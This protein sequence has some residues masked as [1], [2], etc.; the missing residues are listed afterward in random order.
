M[1]FRLHSSTTFW[2]ITEFVAPVSQMP[3]YFFASNPV[4]GGKG[5]FG[6]AFK[7]LEIKVSTVSLFVRV[8]Y[9]TVKLSDFGGGGGI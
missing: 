3:I 2:E 8:S 5:I 1:G 7:G 4:S 6:W 9:R